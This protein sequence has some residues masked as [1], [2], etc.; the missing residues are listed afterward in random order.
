M[1][2]APKTATEQYTLPHLTPP[3]VVP[4]DQSLR[5][6]LGRKKLSAEELSSLHAG[7]VVTLQDAVESPVDVVLGHRVVARAVPIQQDGELAWRVIEI[8]DDIDSH[9]EVIS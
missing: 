8:V 5:V 3:K 9:Q 2:A 1:E 4:A 6:V 7:Q